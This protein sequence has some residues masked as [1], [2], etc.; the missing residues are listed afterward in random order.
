[1]T[2]YWLI[3]KVFVSWGGGRDKETVRGEVEVGQGRW[4]QEGGGAKLGLQFLEVGHEVRE[5][6]KFGQET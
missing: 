1:M 4:V 2:Y 3:V 5:G 6:G